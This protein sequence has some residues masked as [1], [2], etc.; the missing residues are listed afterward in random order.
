MSGDGVEPTATS[1]QWLCVGFLLVAQDINL[2]SYSSGSQNCKIGLN[3]LTSKCWQGWDPFWRLQGRIIPG[4]FQLVEVA[5]TPWLVAP[6][7]FK[8]HPFSNPCF[9]GHTSFSLT[10]TLL[11]F[12]YK[13]PCDNVGPTLISRITSPSQ[14]L[15]INHICNG[16]LAMNAN[17]LTG[18]GD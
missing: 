6:S 15:H 9:H 14:G 11:P 8:V 4:L 2:L 5:R 7:S 1:F 12:S 10:L 17:L 18:T 16:P 3:R 13:D